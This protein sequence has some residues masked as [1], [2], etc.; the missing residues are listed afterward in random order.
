MVASGTLAW[1]ALAL[2]I[3]IPDL[4]VLVSE[5]EDKWTQELC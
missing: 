4:G 3:S 5:R 1:D 2:A